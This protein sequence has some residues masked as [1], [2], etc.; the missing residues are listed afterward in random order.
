M[1]YHIA[2]SVPDHQVR[3]H[4]WFRRSWIKLILA[5]IL[6]SIVLIML[7]CAFFV[8]HSGIGNGLGLGLLIEFL[9]STL[10]P[11]GVSLIISLLI[12]LIFGI[13][14]TICTT[15]MLDRKIGSYQLWWFGLHYVGWS[16][17]LV[18]GFRWLSASSIL[19]EEDGE[20]FGYQI[21]WVYLPL[22]S[23]IVASGLVG[24]Q[25]QRWLKR[26]ES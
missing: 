2:S 18:L 12:G 10:I 8:L 13:V 22:L 9:L 17:L 23:F 25:M 15:W 26:A 4:P 24:W 19:W 14:V 20:Y 7:H 5:T 11:Y 16:A 1:D 6:S 21:L 3:W